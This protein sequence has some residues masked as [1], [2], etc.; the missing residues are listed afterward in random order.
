MSTEL[1]QKHQD[2]LRRAIAVIRARGWAG[3]A[4]LADSVNGV[5][6]H[7]QHQT[8]RASSA[9]AV[10]VNAV[11]ALPPLSVTTI[12][13]I[14]RQYGQRVES[15]PDG[16]GRAYWQF[17][18]SELHAFTRAA[19]EADR[20]RQQDMS[21]R[22]A[23]APARYVSINERVAFQALM[24]D[25]MCSVRNGENLTTQSGKVQALTDFIDSELDAAS[26]CRAEGGGTNPDTAQGDELPPLPAHPDTRDAERYRWLRDDCPDLELMVS[27]W[28]YDDFDKAIDEARA[29][30]LRSL[31]I[32]PHQA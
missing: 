23:G 22:L 16:H 29:A 5:L 11:D 27:Q 3:D 1:S 28:L 8:S 17:T 18:V 19:V 7:L 15:L 30:R 13:D 12:N 9:A 2:T 24:V 31:A 10:P 32:K 25:L 26:R 6:S 14:A 20:V 21:V 4:Q